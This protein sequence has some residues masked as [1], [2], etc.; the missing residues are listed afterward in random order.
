MP[1][2]SG[3]PSL[4]DVARLAGVSHITVSRVM[5]KVS[6]VRATTRDSVLAAM[7]QL[8]YQPNAAARALVTGRSRSIG[9]VC[10]NTALFGP[11]AALLGLEQAAREAGYAVTIVGIDRLDA[12]S[13]ERSVQALL[14]QGVAGVA[15]ISPQVAVAD[16]LRDMPHPL[17]MVTLWGQGDLGV[18]NIVAA[19]AQGAR[20][21]TTHLLELGHVTVWHV[22]GPPGRYGAQ[23]REKAWRATLRAAGAEAPKVLGGDWSARSGYLAGRRLLRL[24]QASAVFVA[25]DQMAL[26]LLRALHEAG[27]RVPGDISVV[28]FDDLPEAA[29][30]TPPL[31]TIRQDF[32]AIGAASLRMLLA[33]IEGGAAADDGDVVLPVTLIVRQSTGRR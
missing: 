9:V 3:R 15:I 24:P 14:H 18:P 12:R 23:E 20:L 17:P 5:N 28:G 26:G 1:T 30:F 13:V 10:Y 4:L 22:A 16:A 2:R 11:A 31:T 27:R 21:A 8:G 32:G 7:R 33:Q 29:Y 19:E 25:S 6:G